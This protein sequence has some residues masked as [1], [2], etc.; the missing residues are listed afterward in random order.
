MLDPA[1]CKAVVSAPARFWERGALCLVGG[2]C[3]SRLDEAAAF[4][5]RRM[6][7]KSSNLRTSI[8]CAWYYSSFYLRAAHSCRRVIETKSGQN[9]MLD[10][11]G[12]KAVSA[13]ARFW[14]R[15]A[16]C[17]VGGLCV[18]GL[19]E[20]AAFTG[21]RMTRK[22]S[23]CRSSTGESRRAYCGLS[24]FSPR[25]DWFEY[26]MPGYGR[27]NRLLGSVIERRIWRQGTP[28]SGV[29]SR[30][31]G[32]PFSGHRLHGQPIVLHLLQMW[33]ANFKGVV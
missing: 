27:G 5:G 29:Q 31:G 1:G 16:L 19:D 10:P 23:T 7:R 14:E 13:P 26:V 28:R 30:A 17:F 3:V 32:F 2:L 18:S 20:A 4:T 9:R 25:L 33:Y 11:G 12:C 22:S 21:R 8:L 24:L 15:G 6:T